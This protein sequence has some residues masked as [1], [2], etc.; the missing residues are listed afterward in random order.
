LHFI[1]EIESELEQAAAKSE[2]AGKPARDSG[3]H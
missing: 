1:A 2:R 3:Q